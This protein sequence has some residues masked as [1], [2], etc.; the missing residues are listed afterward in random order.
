MNQSVLILYTSR[1][2]FT[3]R[4][5]KWLGEALTA[6]VYA[7]DD[8]S[9][10]LLDAYDLI[11]CGGGIY[12]QELSG[13][14]EFRRLEKRHPSARFLYFATGVRPATEAVRR[15]LMDYNFPHRSQADFFYL[16]G[17][18]DP[19][20]LDS[21]QKTLLSL[22]KAMLKRRKVLSAEDAHMLE[23]LDHSS[24]FTSQDELA[25]LLAYLTQEGVREGGAKPQRP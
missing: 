10:P 20:K 7:L 14:K 23:L 19:E 1:T 17:G 21:N 4:Y 2:G 12:G 5:A 11:L 8:K 16:R 13:I 6:P 22:Y 3:A 25:P 24:D 18:L 9:C 15:Q